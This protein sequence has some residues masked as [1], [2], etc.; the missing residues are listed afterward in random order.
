MD[1]EIESLNNWNRVR[2]L[3]LGF[4]LGRSARARLGLGSG[5]LVSIW[6]C[7]KFMLNKLKT[8]HL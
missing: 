5:D 2:I 8:A 7:S 4:K 3:G 1:I 6:R